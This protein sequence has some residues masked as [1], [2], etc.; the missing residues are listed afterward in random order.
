MKLEEALQKIFGMHQF[1]IK[2]GLE[3]I[4]KLLEHLGNPQK[5]F[6]AIHVAGSNGK[7]STA[8][9]LSSILM[10]AGYK[11]GLYTSP[12][13]V[14]FNERVRINGVEIPDDYISEFISD[15]DE[16]IKK[17][18]PTFFEITTALGF[19]Y[20][21]EN[22]LDIAVI[23]TG[24][25]GRL[26]ATNTIDPLASLIT[27]ISLEHTNILG[28]SLEQIAAEKAGIIKNKRPVF[29][30]KMETAAEGVLKK[31]SLNC[32]SDFFTIKNFIEENED[33]IK[34]NLE[35]QSYTIYET[36]LR[37]YYQKYNSALAVLALHKL[38]NIEEKY[39][40]L[41]I[42]NVVKN[43]GIMGRFEVVNSNPLVIF[44]AAHNLEGV[45]WFCDEFSKVN[46]NSRNTT[47]IFG[48]MKDKAIANM[49]M[50]L[51]PFFN[52]IIFTSIDYER[53][54]TP[55]ELLL[56]SSQLG[57]EAVSTTEPWS[58]IKDFVVNKKDEVLCVLGSI[59]LL[60]KIKENLKV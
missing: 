6:K 58:I 28:E 33:Y 30:G 23:E 2:L 34:L 57:F 37:G 24:L 9:Y 13:F 48:A 50:K 56:I 14:K 39:L 18:E 29:I 22:D 59:Y 25:G 46:I 36:T 38:F 15:L 31:V 52:K 44:D 32:T 54:S 45:N 49:L 1:S 47:L 7:G 42:K 12:H 43:S 40:T 55:E 27:S 8:S 5:K 19:K 53:A 51:K 4:N 3:N 11:T 20:F 21:A 35:N 10:E 17:E 41:G 60:G 26:D 16:Y